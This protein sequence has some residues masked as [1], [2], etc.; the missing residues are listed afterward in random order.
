M[1]Q[2]WW[3][4]DFLDDLE[5]RCFLSLAFLDFLDESFLLFLRDGEAD[6]DRLRS[7]RLRF[8]RSSSDPRP[9]GEA[10]RRRLLRLILASRRGLALRLRPRRSAL[11][12]LL[13]LSRR[14]RRL[15]AGFLLGRGL[16][17]R[18]RPREAE[19]PKRPGDLRLLRSRLGESSSLSDDESS[20]NES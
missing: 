8:L 3:R 17:L 15:P 2:S 1:A 5:L 4:R 6:T 7:L 20:L 13:R 12:L 16:W 14:S 11:R 9:P 10:L 19:R 18:L